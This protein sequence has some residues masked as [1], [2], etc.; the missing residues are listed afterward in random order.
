MAEQTAT[1]EQQPGSP[2]FA[3]GTASS[4]AIVPGR[5]S[6]AAQV[7]RDRERVRLWHAANPTRRESGPQQP[8]TH[9]LQRALTTEPLRQ[10]IIVR[11]ARDRSHGRDTSLGEAAQGSRSASL[12][13][14]PEELRRLWPATGIQRAPSPDEVERA[15]PVYEREA[16]ELPVIPLR[17]ATEFGR[18]THEREAA[19]F[20]AQPAAPRRVKRLRR[21]QHDVAAATSKAKAAEAQAVEFA[22]DRT[23]F[24]LFAASHR[25]DVLRRFLTTPRG[26]EIR[27]EVRLDSIARTIVGK[28]PYNITHE[29]IKRALPTVRDLARDEIKRAFLRPQET[30]QR[31]PAVEVPTDEPSPSRGMALL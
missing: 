26:R 23:T 11:P 17:R 8:N 22:L 7:L 14:L 25:T 2:A 6:T 20:F 12:E 13:R 28:A 27:E 15:R 29:T 18:R 5:L 4:N 19:A 30:A 9:R 1:R 16:V 24:E 10:D 3:A 21:E 31:I